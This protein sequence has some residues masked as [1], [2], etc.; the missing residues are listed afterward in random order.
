MAS[1]RRSHPFVHLTGLAVTC[2]AFLARAELPS[3][4]ELADLSL[5]QLAAIAVTSV[6]KK[7]QSLADAPASIYVITGQDIR[8]SGARS[9]AEAL[10]L[11]PN[12]Q[13]AQVSASGYAIRA[14][15]VTNNS[16]NKLLVMIDG[17]SVYSPLFSGVF[18]D[19]Q[20][21]M[22][23][24]IDRIEVVSGPGGTLWGVNAVNGVINVVTRSAAATR[25]TLVAGDAGSDGSQVALRHGAGLGESAA[26]RVYATYGDQGS[27]ET[28][29]GDRVSD[30]WHKAQAGIRADGES[31]RDAWMLQGNAYRG[32]IGQPLPG[33]ISINGTNLLL[34]AIPVRGMNLNARWTRR[35]DGGSEAMVQAYYDRTERTVPPTFAEKLDIFD[36]QAQHAMSFGA[37]S[38]VWGGEARYSID[39]VVNSDYFAFLPDFVHQGWQ[40]VF[41]QGDT[42]VARDV[43]LIVGGRVERNDYTGIEFLPSARLAWKPVP[44]HLLWTAASRTVRAPSRLERDAFVPGKPPFLLRGGPDA[45]SEIAN[46]FEVGYRGQGE[47]VTGSLTVFHAD[48]DGLHTQEISSSRTFLVFAGGMDAKVTGIEAWAS[49]QPSPQWLVSAGYTGLRQRFELHA[50]SNDAGAVA[51]AGRDPA[52]AWLAR[53]AFSPSQ[54]LNLDVTLRGA[55]ALA[56]PDVPKYVVADV[57]ASWEPRRG[58]QLS[59][60]ARNLGGSHAEF[61]ALA[62]RMELDRAFFAGV[63]WEFDQR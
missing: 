22:L 20:D 39:R 36:L 50:G 1:R 55:A 61:G 26:V 2:L 54:R 17:R 49:W 51:L 14:R 60:S 35:L 53:A 18:W 34:G 15:G 62:T 48:Y 28:A 40:S 6:S 25:G 58:V 63:R 7:A 23:E 16:A 24:D 19:V 52:N 46:V 32:T 8:R 5:E 10:R 27:S 47:Y 29:S 33:S 9:I 45:P 21:V 3:T 42:P 43:H 30:A 37:S 4:R 44:H 57:R 31:G 59:V 38:L 13:V 56:S 12:L 11:A 41:A